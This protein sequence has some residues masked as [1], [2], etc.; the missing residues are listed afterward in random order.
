MPSNASFA[1]VTCISP[2][3][4]IVYYRLERSGSAAEFG[5]ARFRPR[6]ESEYSHVWGRLSII[7]RF[8]GVDNGTSVGYS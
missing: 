4:I 1:D 6:P 3:H 5:N 7:I 8:V 2:D